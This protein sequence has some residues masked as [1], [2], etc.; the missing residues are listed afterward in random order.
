MKEIEPSSQTPEQLVQFLDAQLAMQ[1][2]RKKT[3]ERNRTIFLAAALLFI[4][5]AAA[6]A[7]M[8]LE[9]MLAN[10]PREGRQP[11]SSEMPAKRNF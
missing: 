4:M 3:P 7:L 2:A 1:R 11:P 9:E 10:A 6:A 5:G 8:V